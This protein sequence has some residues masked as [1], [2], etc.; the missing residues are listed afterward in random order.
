[1]A[2]SIID[3]DGT[4]G[5]GS[6]LNLDVPLPGNHTGRRLIKITGIDSD[7]WTDFAWNDGD[8]RNEQIPAEPNDSTNSSDYDPPFV[9]LAPQGFGWVE[10]NHWQDIVTSFEPLEFEVL[11]RHDIPIDIEIHDYD[12]RPVYYYELLKVEILK[13]YA[14]FIQHNTSQTPV[15]WLSS[16]NLISIVDSIVQSYYSHSDTPTIPQKLAEPVELVRRQLEIV[17]ATILSRFERFEQGEFLRIAKKWG[18]KGSQRVKH[19][20]LRI[21]P[22]AYESIKNKKTKKDKKESKPSLFIIQEI[23]ISSFLRDYGLGKTIKTF[24]LLPGEET[25]I[26]TRSWRSDIKVVSKATTIIDS[27]DESSSERFADTVMTETTDATTRQEENDW[28]VEGSANSSFG[29]GSASI[30]GGASGSAK[31]SMEEFAKSVNEAVSE[32]VSES[33]SHRENTVN[34][35]SEQT[36]SSE[37]EVIV[38]RNIKNINLQHTLNFVFR[39][40]NQEYLTKIFLKDVR[41]GFSNSNPNSWME[42][43]L[44]QMVEFLDKLITDPTEKAE[45]VDFIL[46]NSA[47]VFNKDELPIQSI[48]KVEL[49]DCGTKLVVSDPKDIPYAQPKLNSDG[50]CFYEY[51]KDFY[52]RFNPD[53]FT[54]LE[55]ENEPLVQGVLLA[56]SI[57]VLKTDSVVIEALLGM[58]NALDKY[59]ED[60]QIETI[61]TKKLQNDKEELAIS[62]VQNDDAVK[63]DLFKDL[64]NDN[65]TI[66]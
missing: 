2:E 48:Q 65:K 1:M 33:V 63:A 49:S 4:G 32:H 26:T 47:V 51:P 21:E 11:E 15:G 44:S 55:V 13:N 25:K 52:Y 24:S 64:Y 38:E 39:E 46:K 20:P 56:E 34:T 18:P 12:Q 29:F 10:A 43:S 62:I 41:I 16:I 37:D 60:L 19:V 53:M 66:P 9:V 61:R 54:Q 58:N 45:I 57:Q 42:S 36:I 14:D 17:G 30:S 6:H 35:S 8:S 31:A 3:Y 27:L 40:L 50:T 7:K 22:Q 5:I 28:Q 59:S 23:G